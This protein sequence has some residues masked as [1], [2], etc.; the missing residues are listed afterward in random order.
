MNNRTKQLRLLH[1]SH[2]NS[3]TALINLEKK[4]AVNDI[5]VAITFHTDRIDVLTGPHCPIEREQLAARVSKGADFKSGAHSVTSP[6]QFESSEIGG[7]IIAPMSTVY[8]FAPPT[9]FFWKFHFEN[10]DSLKFRCV[11]PAPFALPLENVQS[12]SW[13]H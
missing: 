9:F 1:T 12:H 2:R 7:K 5:F 10:F 4:K 6:S 3:N 11:A 13:F 8:I